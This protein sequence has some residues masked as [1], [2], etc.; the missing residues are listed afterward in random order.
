MKDYIFKG[1]LIIDG[2]LSDGDKSFKVSDINKEMVEI[3]Y[4]YLK[5]LRDNGELNPGTFYRIIDYV[6]TTSEVNTKSA[7]HQFDIIVLALTNNTLSEEAWACKND[8]DTYFE[9]SNLGAWKLWYSLDNDTNKFAWAFDSDIKAIKIKN[10][11]ENITFIYV[12]NYELDEKGQFAWTYLYDSDNKEIDEIS[13]WTNL[14]T[15]DTFFTDSENVFIGDVFEVEGDETTVLD[16]KLPGTGVIYRMIDK[17]NND[18]P[19]DFKNIQF[20]IPETIRLSYYN[21]YTFFTVFYDGTATISDKNYYVYT[22][23]TNLKIYYTQKS[24]SEYNSASMVE[25]TGSSGGPGDFNNPSYYKVSGY[26]VTQNRALDTYKFT[27]SYK[28]VDASIAGYV[29]GNLLKSN[30][31]DPFTLIFSLIEL[32]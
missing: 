2:Y 17:F 14:D 16:R 12:R 10:V 20:R 21:G 9:N 29:K 15:P 23:Y 11:D 4:H 31:I 24:P 18:V 1:N 7:Q 6:T 19:Y 28:N 25:Y 26:I 30:F 22:N 32:N 8:K 13:D 5:E 27:F 3:S